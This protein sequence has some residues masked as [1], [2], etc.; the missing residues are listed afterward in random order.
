MASQSPKPEGDYERERGA[1]ACGVHHSLL[2]VTIGTERCRLG[3]VGRVALG[4]V[5]M[6]LETEN[7]HH[8]FLPRLL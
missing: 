4:F 7:T 1:P 5:G 8:P 2:A 6:R 3:V